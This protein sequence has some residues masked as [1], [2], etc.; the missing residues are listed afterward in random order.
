MADID[1]MKTGADTVHQGAHA[2]APQ[3]ELDSKASDKAKRVKKSRPRTK[4]YMQNRELSWLTFNERV[5]DQ[6]VD[7]NVPLLERMKFIAIWRSNLQEF[8][9]V[10]VG[11]LLD[12]E[13]AKE[14][15]YDSKTG[16]TPTEQLESVYARVRELTPQVSE[17]FR[18][19]R[20]QLEAQGIHQLYPDEL[21][22][23]Q[24]DQLNQYLKSNVLP[25]ISP[26]IVN[27]THPFPHLENG[28]LYIAV[29]LDNL[30]EPKENMSKER[31]KALRAK[32]AEDVLMGIIPMPRNCPR[33]IKLDSEGEGYSFI[34]L[35]HALEMVADKIF[36]MYPVKHANVIQVTRNAD[37]D[38]YEE[39]DE[40]DE[41]FRSH[42]KRILKKRSRLAPVRLESE[43]PLSGVTERFLAKRLGLKRSQIY[44]VGLPL[45]M[46]YAFGLPSMVGP[47]LAESFVDEPASP[48]WPADLVRGKSIM[49]QVKKKDVMLSYPYE[50]MDAFVHLL[51]EAATDP[52]VISIKITLYRLAS[53]S[54]L[55][56]AL[57]TAAENGK[58]VTAL[59][60]LRARFDESNNIEWSQRFEQAGCNIIY[61]FRDYKVH[62]KI[63]AITRRG[64]DGLE[65]ITQLGTGN[66]NEKT[67]KLYTDLS[68][69]TADP[70]IG[71]DASMFFRSMQLESAT[72]DYQMLMVAPL[73]IKKGICA[74]IDEEI[75]KARAGKPAEILM[76]TNSVTD[77]DVIEKLAEAS[78]A[79]VKVTMLVRGISCLVPGVEGETENIR[80]V[81]VVGRLL[82]HSRIYIFGA[83]EDRKIYLS[84]ADLMTRNLDKR[85]EIAWPVNDPHLREKVQSYFNTM[86][87]D[88]AKLRELKSDG[89]YTELGHFLA[90]DAQGNPIA[91][92]FDA[93]DHLIKEAYIAAERAPRPEGPNFVMH[94]NL[95]TQVE[96]LVEEAADEMAR[97]RE[98]FEAA[99]PV[100]KEGRDSRPKVEETK[101]EKPETKELEPVDS[102]AD[103]SPA[104]APDEN[105]V[106]Y[107]TVEMPP[108]A[109]VEKSAAP[110]A[111]AQVSV[112]TAPAASDFEARTQSVASAHAPA[113][114]AIPVSAV[115]SDELPPMPR[116][117]SASQSASGR[118][119]EMPAKKK[120][121]FAR[122]FGR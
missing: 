48:Q 41:D 42:M 29:R 65:F 1:R 45:D 57:I 7:P 2:A 82:E 43:R 20:H 24:R 34:L 73:M 99:E 102:Y 33:T 67:A 105:K 60:E 116:R 98:E 9:M 15:I 64:A 76:K 61:G 70:K 22:S 58:D 80:V 13:L 84:S 83:G 108:V 47:K 16:M 106:A 88:T 101:T 10:R 25:L 14:A 11:S 91:K 32:A 78:R 23:H 8:F 77:K 68:M 92:P 27:A 122:L 113:K 75:A 36:S 18:T 55:A 49:E 85:V 66:Y 5:L 111:S 112:S 107:A 79:G 17:D 120:G 31:R 46:G 54:R 51:Q 121:F 110:S 117:D 53:Q 63:C 4:A 35:E 30:P 40:Y 95:S 69:I 100:A 38:M 6:S 39:S 21:T 44:A 104:K 97:E 81:S 62:S 72:D 19:V 12:L 50:S 115:P 87:S 74:Y 114:A 71:E 90:K 3:S 52:D 109:S 118:P 94:A 26:Q 96:A 28:A 37:L 89:T 86:L 93:Q 119:I 56:E 59:F 103:D